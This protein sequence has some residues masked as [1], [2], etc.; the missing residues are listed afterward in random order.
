[1]STLLAGVD[2]GGTTI[3]AGLGTREGQILARKTVPT[4]A[5][6]GPEAVLRRMAGLVHE[7]AAQV[8]AG[9]S[10][11]GVGVPGLVER[12]TGTTRFLP[13]LPTQWRGVPVAEILAGR[14]GCPVRVLND[15]RTATLG[16][17]RFGHGRTARTMAF[18]ALGTG[19]GGGVVIDGKLR[20]GPLGAAGEL[21]HQ[22]ILPDGPRCGCGS[23]G[24]L[25]T[26]ASGPAISAEGVRLLRS[27]LALVLHSLTEGDADRV[28]PQT[29]ARAA[30]GGD[31]TVLEALL[32]AATWLGIG[33]AN[34]VTV[35]HP[36]LVVLGG[37]VAEVGLL[38]LDR[39]RVV[40]RERVRMFPTEDLRIERSALG[41]GAGLLGAI[42]LAAG[43]VEE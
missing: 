30:E 36:D 10:A 21:G 11:A 38:L 14:L 4:R 40:V 3:S 17:L 8:G 27:G 22:T 42:A 35:L 18:F 29:M 19:I 43:D 25:E 9:P 33:V 28:S 41:E 20:L 39:V 16:E 15:V 26:L 1:M 6:E 37:G 13:N 24:C 32:R 34:V 23:R 5:E 7:L 31:E 2:L 12:A